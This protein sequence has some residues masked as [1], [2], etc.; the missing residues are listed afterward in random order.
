MTA[1]FVGA[2]SFYNVIAYDLRKIMSASAMIF[3]IYP[4]LCTKN[5]HYGK[6]QAGEIR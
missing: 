4:Y 1:S 5:K 6:R 2:V 3:P